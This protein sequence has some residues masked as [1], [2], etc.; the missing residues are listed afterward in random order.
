MLIGSRLGPYEVLAKLGAGGMGEVYRA[1]DTKLGREV[2]LKILPD[3]FASDPDRLMRF[4]REARTLAAL[5]HPHIAQVYGIE[6]SPSTGSGQ[7]ATRALVMELVAG[8]DL[9]ARIARGPIPL[10]EAL[11]IARQ[12]AEALEAAHE[13]GIIHR[14]LKPANIKVRDDGTVKVLDFGL[15]K[16]LDPGASSA[17]GGTGTAGD[18]DG[19]AT[20]TSPAM[21]M[22]GIILGTAA[23]MAPEQAK[24]K[25]VDRRADIWAFGCVLY[26][27]LTGRRAFKG[28]D[29]T[30]TLTAVLR[31]EPDW[32]ALPAET[33]AHV[34][35]LLRRCLVKD[36][37][38]RLR[39]I[40]DA[41]LT[42]QDAVDAFVT[43][44]ST[45]GPAT[46]APVARWVAASLALGALS[47]AGARLTV[48]APPPPAEVRL[49]VPTPTAHANWFAI[50]PDGRRLA[51]V[52]GGQLAIR[53]MD[54]IEVRALPGT[55]GATNPA[56][57]PDGRSIAYTQSPNN[58]LMIVP[59]DGAA[60]ET[61]ADQATGRPA[62]LSDGEIVFTHVVDGQLHRVR[63]S[64]GATRPLFAPDAQ[65]D[66]QTWPAV[67]PGTDRVL[68]LSRPRGDSRQELRIGSA[69]AGTSQPVLRADSMGVFAGPDTLLF[70]R[71]DVLFAQPFDADRSA[72][73]GDPVRV[74]PGVSFNAQNGRGGFD[75]SASG[76][77]V[78]R[79]GDDLAAAWNLRLLSRDG[80]LVTSFDD[81]SQA[82]GPALSPDGTRVAFHRMEAGGGDVWM[83]DLADAVQRR[84]TFDRSQENASP[85]W[86]PDGTR[87]VFRSRRGAGWAL[88]EK[89]AD[90]AGAETTLAEFPHIVSPMSWSPDG[91]HLLFMVVDPDTNW[92][93]WQYSFADRAA[94][95]LLNSPVAEG[96]PQ[97]SPDG[98]WF[99]YNANTATTQQLFIESFPRGRGKWQLPSE[100]GLYPRWR[101]DGRELYFLRSVATAT[102]EVGL[103]V[104]T[105]S[106]TWAAMAAEV[107][108]AGAGLE[109]G[110]PRRLFEALG[111]MGGISGYS[112]NYIGWAV[113]GDGQRFVLQQ[114]VGTER[115]GGL[116]PLVVIMHHPALGAR[117]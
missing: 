69:A 45:P 86:S 56:W 76:T 107:R 68:Y 65:S 91:T 62:W 12:I 112:G 94:T 85:V 74:L 17:P 73:V 26:E 2:A 109:F 106:D 101:A 46:R 105:G 19:G 72:I 39:D 83:L 87:I 115:Q 113:S 37:K 67:L 93:I 27:M 47:F 49:E 36:P 95:P 84:V 79:P 57:S 116:A 78:A 4:E 97:F 35:V 82:L 11:P 42:L 25:P 53:H 23:Y 40:G 64:G 77:I 55:E 58:R 38:Q 29:I 13:A 6:D 61:T 32:T 15:A 22:R 41:R 66:R 63:A 10:D 52:A 9:S 1:R 117:P 7:A 102:S 31:D 48:P 111:V 98:R 108:T 81:A 89:S 88:A 100:M 103:V 50:S 44:T 33:P 60:P 3:V 54:A 16:A 14:D 18:V 75:A 43:P 92:D 34:R 70:L 114:P 21:T 71:N 90:G 5:N 110:P 30:D 51:F 96:F 8:E 104:R 24:G 99:A 59:I 20:V 28:E 80:E